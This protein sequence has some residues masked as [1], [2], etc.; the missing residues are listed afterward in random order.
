MI[1]MTENAC[2][3][4]VMHQGSW[5]SEAMNA[6]MSVTTNAFKR[7]HTSLRHAVSSSTASL[8]RWTSKG[9]RNAVG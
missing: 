1:D 2:Y 7:T 9:D 8:M 4:C 6:Y 3:S 5:S